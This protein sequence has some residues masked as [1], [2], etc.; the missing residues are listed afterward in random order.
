MTLIH[1][2]DCATGAL[3]FMFEAASVYLV[4]AWLLIADGKQ[5]EFGVGMEVYIETIDSAG[6][7]Q[8]IGKPTA[9]LDAQIQGA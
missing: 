5:Y 7:F 1:V 9:R 6:T 8:A 4:N 2:R 3:L